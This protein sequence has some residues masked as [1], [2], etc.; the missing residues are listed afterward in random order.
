[1]LDIVVARV[2]LKMLRRRYPVPKLEAPADYR[3]FS[4]LSGNLGGDETS[5][6]NSRTPYFASNQDLDYRCTYPGK[7]STASAVPF[8]FE[9]PVA[10]R[11]LIALPIGSGEVPNRIPD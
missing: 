4:F 2:I 5:E 8:V 3:G 6:R 10:S 9:K 7:S 11:I 1:M